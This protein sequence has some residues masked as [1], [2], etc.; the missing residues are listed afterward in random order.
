MRISVVGQQYPDSL[1]KNLSVTLKQMGHIVQEVDQHMLMPTGNLPKSF[2]PFLALLQQTERYQTIQG[3]RVAKSLIAFHPELVINTYA[4]LYPIA[5]GKVR[6]EL[7]RSTVIVFL[8]PDANANL[9]REYALAADYDLWFFKDPFVVDL[10]HTHLGI[11]VH[12][13]PEACNPIWHYP[14]EPSTADRA[15]Y[16]CDLTTAGNMYYY[17][18][19]MLNMFTEYDLKIWG[20]SYPKWLDSPLRAHYPGLYIAETEKAKALRSAKIVLNT[21]SHK[22]ISGIN[23]RAFEVA[24]CGGFQIADWRPNMDDLFVEDKEI[25]IFRS[26]DELKDKV[27]Y[28]LRKPE[29][30]EQ[31]AMAGCRR[32]HADHTYQ[33]RLEKIFELIS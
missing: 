16:G 9:G 5:I 26:R 20:S 27:D 28:Y 24:G 17:R 12:Y 1:A 13:L 25:V 31:I 18:A 23:A 22:E 11:N 7:G 30:R 32:A 29:Q 6:A 4:E 21:L 3:N 14:I 15:R 2:R 8:Y 10:F 19:L 33:K